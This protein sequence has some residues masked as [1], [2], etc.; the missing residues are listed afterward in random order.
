MVIAHLINHFEEEYKLVS[1]RKPGSF[2]SFLKSCHEE[3][4][5]MLAISPKQ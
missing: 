5:R 3:L 4:G 2:R 1:Q